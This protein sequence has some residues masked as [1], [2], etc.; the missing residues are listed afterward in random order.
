[1]GVG[2][3]VDY[4]AKDQEALD[5]GAGRGVRDARVKLRSLLLTA[6]IRVPSTASNSRPNR[7]SWRQSS[8]NSR[9]T[10]RKALRLSRRKSAMVLK[11]GFKCRSSQ[12]TSI[13]RPTARPHSVQVAVDVELQQIRGRIARAAR[14]PRLNTA[15]RCRRK[16]QPIDNRID[17][18]HRVVRADIIV[19]HLQQEQYLGSVV[20][21]E[22]HHAKF[23]RL[24]RRGGI[25]SVRLFTRSASHLHDVTNGFE[26]VL[27][28]Y[29]PACRHWTGCSNEGS[30]RT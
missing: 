12:I 19:N 21:R 3:L 27:R 5:I 4:A 7:S 18:A 8:T 17:K 22:V 14:H 6:L 28:G 13:L 24:T 30:E 26:S 9:K 20:A 25:R 29:T 10:W 16:I 15:K 11:S 23:Y 2:R 1:M